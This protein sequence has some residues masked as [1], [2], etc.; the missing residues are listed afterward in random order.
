MGEHDT[1]WRMIRQR[2]GPFP[3]Q[4]YDFVRKGLAHTTSLVHGEKANEA[5]GDDETSRHVTGRQLCFGLRNY[6]QR[7]YGRL[8][9][10]VLAHW[11]IHTTAD[12][13][14]IVFAMIDA[15]MMRKND[16][17]TIEDFEA[18]FD[19]DEAFADLTPTA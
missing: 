4:A 10:T 11:Q 2:T 9:R 5:G 6:A 18:V 12:F 14:R 13:G 17:D 7:Q 15:G 19:F 16:D 1:Q 8:A 3:P